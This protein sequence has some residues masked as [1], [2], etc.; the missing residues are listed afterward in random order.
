MTCPTRAA[1]SGPTAASSS[2]RRSA[3]RSRS[4]ASPTRA[5]EDPA[6]EA[7]FRYELKHYVGRPSPVYHAK[8]LSQQC[9]GAQIYI[10]REDLN[11]T[12]AH[13]IN[14]TIGQALLARR[15]KKQ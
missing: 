4:C 14:N 10:K 12:G 6:F 11:H 5:R 2:P 7:E 8:R 3:A 9:G 15:M 13:K 1:T